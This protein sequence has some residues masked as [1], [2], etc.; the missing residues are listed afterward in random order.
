MST[1]T[2]VKVKGASTAALNTKSNRIE[3]IDLLR[4]TVMIIMAL[5]H[6]RDYFHSDA[7]LYEPTDLALTNVP[8]FLTR[9]I[10]HYCAPIFVF[11]AGASAYLYG[12]KKSR[13]E[14]SFFLLTRGIWLVLVELFIVSLFRTFN[15]TYIYSNLQVIWAIG[16]SMIALAAIIYMKRGFIL[17]LGIVLMAG[18]NLLDNVHVPGDNMLSFLWALLH[19]M[20]QF[21]IGHFLIR[22]HYPLLPWI[23]IMAT[24][25]YFGYLYSRGYNSVKRNKTLLCLGS[26]AIMLFLI[27]RSFNLYGDA[28][29][30]SIQKDNVFT[31]LSFL[32]VS[33]YPPSFLYILV[34]LGPA[35]IFLALAEKP[36]NV[37]TEKIAIFGRVAMFYYLAHIL[38]IHV[39]ATISAVILGYKFS[40]MVLSTSLTNAAGLK[41]YGFNL[42]FVY[43]V[44]IALILLLYPLCKRFD[45]YKR[46]HQSIKWWLSY[47]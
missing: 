32:N 30:W 26:G 41:G 4:G 19:E 40:D 6:V 39:L 16:I 45:E 36:L 3:S 1:V 15:P 7:F 35:L 11:L 47:F 38:L 8:L 10:T 2:L 21:T 25:Y 37:I 22:I 29:H 18:H 13:K 43:N 12:A 31:L 44:W 5:D 23:G 24:G 27:L 9:F 33:K 42:T 46:R 20:K 17:C 14:L 28:A 34:T